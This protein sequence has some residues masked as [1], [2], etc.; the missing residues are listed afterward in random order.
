MYIYNAKIQIIFKTGYSE[1]KKKS[2]T[3]LF[4]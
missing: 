1:F 2:F 3:T 4:P